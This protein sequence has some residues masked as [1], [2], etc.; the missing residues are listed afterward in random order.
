M[1]PVTKLYI[2]VFFQAGIPFGLV[3]S[4]I[5]LINGNGFSWE[6]F[7]FSFIGFGLFMSLALVSIHIHRLK[8][9]GVQKFT[10][11]NLS[12]RQTKIVT[13]PLNLSEMKQKLK[14]DLA[15][16]KMKMTEAQNGIL[17]DSKVTWK[18][19][20]EK[21]GVILQCKDGGNYVY[22]ISSKPRLTRTIIDFGKNL[23][24]VNN[25]EQAITPHS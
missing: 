14:S 5:D 15:L 16:E 9:L 19:W 6:K 21:I 8:K 24:N 22:H 11:E 20:G 13:S 1:N 25:I 17:L 23:V 10:D 2:K 3:M 18:S 12:V 4:A 7:L